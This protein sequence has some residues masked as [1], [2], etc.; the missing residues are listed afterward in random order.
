M[1]AAIYVGNG[2]FELV[3]KS[4]PTPLI[5]ECLLE[6]SRAGICGTDLRIFQGHMHDR[7]GSRR[8]LGHE[9]VSVVRET[10]SRGKFQVGD[11]VVV[12]P[13]IF[14]G[15]CM[16]CQKG[17]THVCQNLRILGIDEDGAFQQF[18]AVPEKRLHKLSHLISDDHAAMIEPLA[19]AVHSVRRAALRAGETVAVIGAGPI[20]L[21]IA[22]LAQKTGAKVFVLEINPHRLEFARRLQL[23]TIDS[24]GKNAEKTLKDLTQGAGTNV[25][26]EVSGSTDAARIMTVLPAVHGRVILV[27]IHSKHTPI[28]L[29]QVFLKE[30]SIQ[31]VR[32][33]SHDDFT[34]AI[35]QLSEGEIDLAPFISK[36]YP[37]EELQQAMELAI[38][39]APVMKT[40]INFAA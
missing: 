40:L 37:L 24:T 7:V 34:E 10:F 20:G 29:Y 27:G 31:G 12:E 4:M 32:A 26:F 22:L 39:G 13:T 17:T 15:N 36:Q 16:A 33:Y 19:V 18:W 1:K 38:S 5:G 28:D 2:H 11:R 25:L 9:A 3:E 35:R 30:L 6:M 21:L 23:M 8:I 14:C